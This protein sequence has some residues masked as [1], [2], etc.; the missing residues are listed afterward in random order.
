VDEQGQEVCHPDLYVKT[1]SA[2]DF[3][4]STVV[5]L[6]E[7]RYSPDFFTK[8]GIRHYDLNFEDGSCPSDE[9][10]KRFFAIV[11]SS[12]GAVAVHC[13]AGLGRTGTLIGLWMMREYG[14]TAPQFIGWCRLCRPGSILGPQQELGGSKAWSQPRISLDLYYCTLKAVCG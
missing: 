11:D 14:L 1:F 12:E 4:V 8:H 13:K 9:V 3:A 10:V 2:P 6:N 7:R 5:R